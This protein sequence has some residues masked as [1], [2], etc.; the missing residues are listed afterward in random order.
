VQF[1][2]LPQFCR[3]CRLQDVSTASKQHAEKNID[4]QKMQVKLLKVT[5]FFNIQYQ[6]ISQ[7]NLLHHTQTLRGRMEED[8]GGMFLRRIK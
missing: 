6:F 3:V 8:G 7:R 1:Y 4:E 2:N 5:D